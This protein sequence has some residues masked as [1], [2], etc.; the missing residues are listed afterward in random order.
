MIKLPAIEVIAQLIRA[1]IAKTKIKRHNVFIHLLSKV[2]K[3]EM[4]GIG[5][6]IVYPATRAKIKISIQKGQ[7]IRT[8]WEFTGGY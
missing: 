8:V 5:N 2:C 1:S 3:R 7:I 6:R 4:V